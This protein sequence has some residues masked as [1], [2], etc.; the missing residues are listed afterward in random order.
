MTESMRNTV[1]LR[2]TRIEDTG[3][4]AI[5]LRVEG[6]VVAEAVSVL[7]RECWRSLEE[8]PK[9]RVDFS[10]VTFIDGRGVDMLKRISA[11]RLRVVN[12]SVFVD[13]LLYGTGDR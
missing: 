12:C 4:D 11:E 1:A 7:E 3:P 2:I 6:R 8:A 5:T 9:V 13:H 10:G